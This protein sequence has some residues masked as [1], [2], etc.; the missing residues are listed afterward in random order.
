MSIYIGLIVA[1]PAV[2]EKIEQLHNLTLDDVRALFQA[3]ARPIKVWFENVEPHGPRYLAHAV[4]DRNR[5]I[6]VAL[7]PLPWHAG[8]DADTWSLRTA[9][10]DQ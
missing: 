6:L 7:D 4:D 5:R 3:P 10:V 2:V 9:Y 1:T 8:E